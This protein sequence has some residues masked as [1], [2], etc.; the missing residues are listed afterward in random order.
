MIENLISTEGSSAEDVYFPNQGA[1]LLGDCLEVMKR[2]E[3]NSVDLIL[4]DPP[5]NLGKYSTGNIELS[6]RSDFNNDVAEWDQGEFDPAS[7][8]NEFRRVLSP[9]GTIFAF[10]S[11][12]LIGRWHEIYDP[13]FDT[14]QFIAWHKTNPPPKFRRAGFLNS[15]ELIVCLWD[16]GHKWNFSNQADM[17]NFIESPLCG[18]NERVK[19]P[20]HPTQ[21]PVKVLKRLLEYCTSEGDVVLD[22][23]SGV[24]STAAASLQN[25][26]R[27]I[28]IE[29]DLEF[30]RA[31]VKRISKE[32][33]KP[34]QETLNL[35]IGND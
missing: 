31:A 18:G 23:F 10:T 33:D 6:W 35:I 1:L 2:I 3:D 15:I 20:K 9:T 30:H 7:L 28:G 16:K 22:A 5:Y 8:V 29:R 34:K 25:N 24:G 26:R 4:T 21:K 19:D 17:H 14:F 12:N 13:L 27:F 11:Y 32:I